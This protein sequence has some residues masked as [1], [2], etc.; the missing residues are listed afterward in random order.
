MSQPSS[1]LQNPAVSD[2][3][4]LYHP[5]FDFDSDQQ[6]LSYDRDRGETILEGKLW[7]PEQPEGVLRIRGGVLE[8]MLVAHRERC[9]WM[10]DHYALLQVFE[11]G[12]MGSGAGWVN[13]GPGPF[14]NGLRDATHDQ[15]GRWLMAGRTVPEQADPVFWIG[16]SRLQNWDGKA[17]LKYISLPDV[18]DI[19]KVVDP[20]DPL[21]DVLV[22]DYL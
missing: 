5:I 18:E 14:V 1:S 13:F 22:R 15:T 16:L 9:P 2:I 8:D 3:P 10:D 7:W 21:V 11:R 6:G 4:E 12:M 17:E 20:L 19:C